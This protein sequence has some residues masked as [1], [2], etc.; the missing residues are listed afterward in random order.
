MRST[1]KFRPQLLHATKSSR[2][3]GANMD[4]LA[5]RGDA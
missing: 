2:G 1:A 4:C 5:F 3:F